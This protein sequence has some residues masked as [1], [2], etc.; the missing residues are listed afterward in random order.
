MSPGFCADH[1]TGRSGQP[2]LASRRVAI[3]KM[4]SIGEA[5]ALLPAL[6]NLTRVVSAERITLLSESTVHRIVRRDHPGIHHLPADA[7]YSSMSFGD[8]LAPAFWQELGRFVRAR[9]GHRFD[10]FLCFQTAEY[11]TN[12]L[13]PHFFAKLLRYR[14]SVGFS[15]RGLPAWDWSVPARQGEWDH[16]FRKNLRLVS[17]YGAPRVVTEP[18]IGV[19]RGRRREVTKRLRANSVVDW[20]RPCLMVCPGAADRRRCWPLDRYEAVLEA[21]VDRHGMNVVMIGSREES[22]LTAR[23]AD[24]LPPQHALDTA[25]TFSLEAL[26]ELVDRAD[27]FLAN[28]T[29]PL[30]VA[31][32]RGIP[33][34]GLFG[35]GILQAWA[36]YDLP[37][38]RAL[39]YEDEE[40]PHLVDYRNDPSVLRKITTEDVLSNL[41]SLHRRFV[42]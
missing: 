36:S 7:V 34:V 20:E 39:Y 12:R 1:E 4:G 23:L 33:T 13:K 21:M 30:H 29:G 5:V 38:V 3:L 17:R 6:A 42:A 19:D 22:D 35:P 14:R 41:E 15:G 25:G 32:A 26:P 11:W 18:T 27:L 8:L 2:E 40:D 24:A 9:F 16:M 37:Y 10:D 28:D 31:V